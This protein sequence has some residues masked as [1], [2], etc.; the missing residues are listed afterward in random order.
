MAGPLAGL[1]IIDFGQYIA[2]P[3][4]AVMLAD[5]EADVIHVDPPGGPRYDNI[6]DAFLNRNKRRIILDLKNA[7]EL[8][9]ARR[10]IETA[11]VVIENFRPG[12]MDRL[13]LGEAEMRAANPRLIY[14]SLPGFGKGDP[15][16]EMRAWE[17][18]LHA[19]TAN[20]IPRTGEEPEGWD[21]ERPTYSALPQ[22]SSFSGYL[23]ATSIVMALIARART[24]RGQ[25]VE[26]P[27]FDAMF[28]LIGHSGTY[29]D[30][31]GL[32][33]PAPIKPRGSDCYRCKDGRYVQF[34]TSS[35]RHLTWFARDAGIA[36]E[37]GPEL[38]DLLE[39]AKPE[40]NAELHRRFRELFLTK[41]AEE[42]E[43]IGNESGTAIGFVRTVQEW[44]NNE[45]AQKIG[46]SIKINDPVVGEMLTAGSPIFLSRTVAATPKARHLPGADT[47][48]VLAEL[49]LLEVPAFVEGPEPN[50]A[51]P[52]EG[53]KVVDLGVALAGPT[54]GRLLLEFGAD[55]LKIGAPD[56][57]VSGYLNRGKK[58]MLLDVGKLQGQ[59]V[60]WKL[61][62]SSDVILENMSP[63][64]MDRLGIGYREVKARRPDAIYTSISCYGRTG[65]WTGYR[66]WERQGQAVS[67]MMERTGLP[68]VLGPYNPVDIGTGVFG[69]FATGLALFHKFQTGEGQMAGASLCQTGTY[70]Q[71][72]FAFDFPGHVATEPRGYEALGEGP[73]DRFYRG[74]DK[75][76][77]FV[78]SPGEKA[79]L[80]ETIGVDVAP[81]E[82]DDLVLALE[83]RFAESEAQIWVDRLVAAG[84][85]AHINVAIEDLMVDPVA[86]ARGL[87]ITQHV[88]GAGACTMPGISVRLS[89]TPARVGEAPR[90]PGS[91]AAEVLE[92]LG[93]GDRLPALEK[94]WV[95]RT[96]DLAPAWPAH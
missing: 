45:H 94:D 55:V 14:C 74:S 93:I 38:L 95:I 87:S 5:Q 77:Y 52:L 27:A 92:G 23:G 96:H 90:I 31:S 53:V 44:L 59:D 76:F 18:V 51:H 42:W 2:G 82:A 1:R 4:A 66:G 50:I 48:E 3:L 75:W 33:P 65:P 85:S 61:V 60:Y 39:A 36:E 78:A 67:G 70:H 89:D 84:I 32:K 15:R 86:R 9:A 49:E 88:E 80:S 62:N 20:T 72:I 16:S 40:V 41:T 64:T 46:V 8:G 19:A 63:T 13:G 54:C 24:G 10:L 47:A 69:T 71:S 6:A 7:T 34:D 30:E 28:T 91:D 17:G 68:S 12:V 79:I 37:W 83:K 58:S 21:W 11:D 22:P 35:P 73:L 57:Q 43:Q 29:R 81:L 56:V 25:Y 26:V